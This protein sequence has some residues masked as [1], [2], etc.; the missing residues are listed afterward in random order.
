MAQKLKKSQLKH[1]SQIQSQ[2]SNSK[3][4]PKNGWKLQVRNLQTSSGLPP[5]LGG[6]LSKVF[7][8]R[9]PEP[10]ELTMVVTWWLGGSLGG[11]SRGD[12]R[13][14]CPVVVLLDGWIFFSWK[15]GFVWILVGCLDS[16]GFWLDVWIRLM[17]L[18][19]YDFFPAGSP[20]I[21]QQKHQPISSF[22]PKR[23]RDK[24]CLK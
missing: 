3:F 15:F 22:K 19:S 4:A 14:G 2:K 1:K 9:R 10:A 20:R 8:S 23:C 21:L 24:L 6:A 16:F 5:I 7:S 18:V 17:F 11:E 12:H 13:G